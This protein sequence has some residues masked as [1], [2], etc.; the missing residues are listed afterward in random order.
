MLLAIDAGNT[1]IV[2]AAYDGTR[3]LGLWRCDTHNGWSAERYAEWLRHNMGAA[4]FQSGEY[5][6]A[7]IC[8]V[9]PDV[10]AALAALCRILCGKDPLVV[11]HRNA[12]IETALLRPESAGADRLVNGVAAKAFYRCPAIVV[13]FGTATTFDVID[14]RG[15]FRGGAIMPGINLSAQALHRATAK[16]PQVEVEKPPAVIGNDTVSAIRSGLYWGYAAM[17]EGMLKRLSSEL[18]EK[19]Y[20]IATGGLAGLLSPDIPA[21]EKIDHDLT[22]RGMLH[23]FER[24]VKN[25]E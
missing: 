20:I 4:D 2:F 5:T 16:L 22:L 8:S 7:V 21:I 3:Q 14:A 25:N 6:G 19:P 23:I 18:G 17:V 15:V 1:N 9:V 24:I 10:D 13:D 11:T 12:G